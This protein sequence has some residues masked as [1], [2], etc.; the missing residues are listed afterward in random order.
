MRVRLPRGLEPFTGGVRE[1]AVEAATVA[2]VVAAVDEA[3]PGVA[4]HLVDR[5]GQLRPHL[6]CVVAGEAVRDV[7]TPVDDEVAF[8]LAVSGGS[9]PSL[10]VDA[11]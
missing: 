10:P 2:G 9:G 5:N 4:T 6:V 8:L 11:D 1:M 3:L 7:T